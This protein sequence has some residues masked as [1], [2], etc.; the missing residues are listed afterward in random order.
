METTLDL[1]VNRSI[2][3]AWK[4]QEDAWGPKGW[5]GAAVGGAICVS[6]GIQRGSRLP[7]VLGWVE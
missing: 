4:T 6:G 1:K 5:E 7:L 2:V 3:S